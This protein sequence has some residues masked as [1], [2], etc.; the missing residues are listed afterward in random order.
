MKNT[1][2]QGEHER[3]RRSRRSH[4]TSQSPK[5]APSV[6]SK[7]RCDRSESPRHRD[8]G[9]EAVFIRLGRKEKGVFNRLGGKERCVSARSSDSKP[10]RHWNTQREAESCYQSSRSRKAE[11][12]PRKRYHEGASSQRTKAFLERFMHGIIYPEL[13][14]RLYNNIPKSMDKMMRATIAFLMAEVA[15]SNQARKKTFLAW[16]QQ[17]TRQKQ[18]FN[19]RED[20]KNQQRSERKR[21]RFTLLTKSPREIL[22][23][24][25]GKFKAPPPMGYETFNFYI[26]ELCGGK[27]TIPYNGII[28]RPR[29]RKIQAVPSTAHGMLKFPVPRGILT[30]GSSKLIPLECTMVSG[31]E[32]SLSPAPEGFAACSGAPAERSRRISPN[33]QKK[34]SQAPER[35]KAIQEEVE[36]LVE[37][38]IM[39]EVHITAEATFKQMK[40]ILVELP[41]L[42]TPVEKE[43]LIVYLAAAREAVSVVLMIEWEAKQMP[44]YFVSRA[45]QD[46]IVERPEDDS[47]AAPMEVEEELPD[48]WTLFTDVSSCVDGPYDPTIRIAILINLGPRIAEKM[49]IKNLQTHVDSHLL[50]NQVNGSYIAKEPGIIQY[51][52]KVKTL[53]SGFKKFLIKQVPRSKNKKDDTLSKIA[54]TSFAHLTKHVLVEVLKEKSI[55]EA[56]VL[57]VV[58]EEGNT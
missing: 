38:G 47:L 36:G 11:P 26:D 51:L 42:T 58:E 31:P 22:A 55:N 45:L 24:D 8:S 29:V 23:L 48:L 34:R 14:K 21:D 7:I 44:I 33:R 50:A 17:E 4:S 46:F 2:L 52:K 20:F 35:N 27:I 53:I 25:K 10:Q 43:E 49:R 41:T 57:T 1:E 40:K 3:R 30:L 16:K 5:P 32:H 9:R 12:I 37:A 19:K 39:K 18:N 13:I 28:G 54:S 15:A 6:F 56:K